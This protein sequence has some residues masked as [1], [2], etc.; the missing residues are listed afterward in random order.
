MLFR[1]I[2]SMD[3]RPG[4]ILL[5]KSGATVKIYTGN[6]NDLRGRTAYLPL[7][8]GS[9]PAQTLH[10]MNHSGVVWPRTGLTL[11]ISKES[12]VPR[13]IVR[14]SSYKITIDPNNADYVV[15]PSVMEEDDV[16]EREARIAYIV[17]KADKSISVYYFN[18]QLE[19]SRQSIDDD[20]LKE[21]KDEIMARI[22]I[23]DAGKDWITHVSTKG[24]TSEKAVFSI[25]ANETYDDRVGR[26]TFKQ[27]DGS[28]SA[29]VVVKQSQT[30]GLFITTPEYNLS[31]EAHTLSV[32]VKANVDY[33][34]TSQADWITRVETKAL[35]A[36]TIVLSI[37]ANKGYDERTGLV[38]V[39]QKNGNLTGIITITQKQTDYQETSEY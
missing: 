8:V 1:A 39:K 2:H 36:S 14:N 3:F 5:G 12:K 25:A 4:K 32:E 23:D 21:I 28:L 27:T 6:N 9:E 33:E 30:N 35:T 10:A 19:W 37:A 38:Y 15:I 34:V 17:T 31:N 22:S 20:A 16:I 11:F 13:A 18:V 29:T 26:I 7:S 24:L